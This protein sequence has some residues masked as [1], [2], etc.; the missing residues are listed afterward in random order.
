MYTVITYTCATACTIYFVHPL[1]CVHDI[2]VYYIMAMCLL[3]Y[4]PPLVVVH[5]AIWVRENYSLVF[6]FTNFYFSQTCICF[7]KISTRSLV[8]VFTNFLRVFVFIFHIALYLF[9][10]KYILYS[11]RQG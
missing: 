11:Y 2:S 5:P 6:V 8:F 4:T 1:I 10:V 3:A 9:K 7:F